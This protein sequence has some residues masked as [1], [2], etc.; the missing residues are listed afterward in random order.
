MPSTVEL[1]SDFGAMGCPCTM[2]V[3]S[4]DHHAGQTALAAGRDEVR[5]LESKFSRYRDDSVLTA[6]NRAGRDGREVA[7]D[8]ET[9]HLITQAFAAYQK[10]DHL[11]D[12]TTGALSRLWNTASCT[13]PSDSDI[14][15]CLEGVGMNKLCWQPPVLGFKSKAMEIDLGGLAKEYA[16]DRVCGLLK[17]LGV[18]G[19]L[20]DLGGDVRAFGRQ[21]DDLPWR[22]GI[23]FPKPD[24]DA[25]MTLFVIEG[26]VATSGLYER[27]VIIDGRRYGH[28]VNPITGWPIE[29]RSAY[30]VYA[31][32]C[33]DAGTIASIALLKGDAGAAW[34]REL[35]VPHVEALESGEVNHWRIGSQH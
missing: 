32:T 7:L 13:L 20:V 17:D 19:G 34:L 3:Y 28:V 10:S 12:V 2:I 25:A 16:V 6:I 21:H 14:A 8:A 15:H 5:R 27:F 18:T 29:S 1:R 23:R 35:D 11:F 9:E 4:S 30:S 24:G 26:A 31:S 22:I 33:L